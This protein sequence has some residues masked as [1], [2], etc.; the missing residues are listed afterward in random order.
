MRRGQGSPPTGTSIPPFGAALLSSSIHYSLPPSSITS[1]PPHLSHR[2]SLFRL[3]RDK[4]ERMNT[5]GNRRSR[6][7]EWG[8]GD[9]SG[10]GGGGRGGG[11]VCERNKI[12]QCFMN[13]SHFERFTGRRAG[14][15]GNGVMGGQSKGLEGEQELHCR[16]RG[17]LMSDRHDEEGKCPQNT[18]V[19]QL[20]TQIQ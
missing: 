8:R 18:Y 13:G 19:S 2:T 11:Q 6:R 5:L 17:Q 12:Q 20:Q 1:P 7:A 16:R 3:A 9:G 4:W 15:L 10:G 14:C